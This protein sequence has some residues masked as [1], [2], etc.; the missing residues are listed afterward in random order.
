M[1]T[2]ISSITISLLLMRT[3]MCVQFPNFIS[4]I[5][6]EAVILFA[7]KILPPTVRHDDTTEFRLNHGYGM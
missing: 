4:L 1:S 7:N 5:S 3:V 6:Y 2:T